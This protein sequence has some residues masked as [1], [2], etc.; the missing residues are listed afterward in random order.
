MRVY[1]CS[2]A[3]IQRPRLRL[4][5]G[6]RLLRTAVGGSTFHDKD[7]CPRP[8]QTVAGR[9][10]IPHALDG[11]PEGAL[12]RR[13]AHSDVRRSGVAEQEHADDGTRETTAGVGPRLRLGRRP[14]RQEERG[15]TDARRGQTV[16]HV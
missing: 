3:R 11:A 16:R 15:S 12:A 4:R 10:F 13:P 9:T 7:R 6:G 1:V 8:R 2:D 5:H 14:F